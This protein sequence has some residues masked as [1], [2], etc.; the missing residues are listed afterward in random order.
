MSELFI[1]AAIPLGRPDLWAE[2]R[3]TA[4]SARQLTGLI[5]RRVRGRFCQVWLELEPSQ[6]QIRP[7][8]Y[9]HVVPLKYFDIPE[10]ML[11]VVQYR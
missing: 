1:S 2:G 3:E 4:P 7:S 11:V 8:A 5:A 10:E 9:A 6:G